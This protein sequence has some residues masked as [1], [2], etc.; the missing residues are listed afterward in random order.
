MKIS[1]IGDFDT[2]T[3]FRLA[4]VK[5]SYITEDPNEALRILKKLVREEDSGMIIISEKLAD[6]IRK[7]TSELLEGRIA[8]LLVEIPDKKGPMET[9][10]DPIMKL[11]KKAVGIE[12]KF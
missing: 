3:G 4:G 5:D 10:V 9:K 6:K 2:I 7:E 1:V 12:I 11:I 8:P